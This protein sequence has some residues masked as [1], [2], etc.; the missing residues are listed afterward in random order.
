MIDLV[1]MVRL[2]FACWHNIL[3]DGRERER[4]RECARV[5]E[6]ERERER[7]ERVTDLA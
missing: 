1:P 6:R 2:S 5:R 7:V 3:Y 4:E